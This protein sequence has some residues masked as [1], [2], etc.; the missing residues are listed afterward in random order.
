M[1]AFDLSFNGTP[2]HILTLETAPGPKRQ[3][4]YSTIIATFKRD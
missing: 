3:K 4:V 2:P 1:Y